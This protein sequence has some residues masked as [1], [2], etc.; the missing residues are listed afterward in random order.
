MLPSLGGPSW[1]P[2]PWGKDAPQGSSSGALGGGGGVVLS[3]PMPSAHQ[4]RT[5][6]SEEQLRAAM[7]TGRIPGLPQGKGQAQRLSQVTQGP[8]GDQLR[9]GPRGGTQRVESQVEA[10]G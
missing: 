7:T 3:W 4:N 1:P 6:L 8:P 9:L 5:S 10:W 2:C